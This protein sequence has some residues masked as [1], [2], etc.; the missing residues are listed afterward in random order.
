MKI[1]PKYLSQEYFNRISEVIEKAKQKA[2]ENS[3]QAKRDAHESLKRMGLLD[4]NGKVKKD[5]VTRERN[6]NG[7]NNF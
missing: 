3:E 5:I 7:T 2:L 4:E 6:G 1:I